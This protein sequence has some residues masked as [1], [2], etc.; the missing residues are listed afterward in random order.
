MNK[1]R[2]GAYLAAVVACAALAISGCG[3]P[4]PAPRETALP[5]PLEVTTSTPPGA[6]NRE[7]TGTWRL[8]N[9][10]EVTA[11]STTVHIEVSRLACAG[12]KTGK[13]LKPEV[14]EEAGRVV[15]RTSVEPLGG[16]PGDAYTCQGNNWVPVTVELP[17]AIGHS[18]LFDAACSDRFILTTAFCYEDL[19]VRWKP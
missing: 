15:I 16:N 17:S 3:Q 5:A 12:G 7:T 1:S 18:E 4:A 9:P 11:E 14:Q 2:R 8:V 19:G 10:G 6:D 13:V